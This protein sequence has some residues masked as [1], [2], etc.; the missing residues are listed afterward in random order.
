MYFT[1]SKSFLLAPAYRR[2]CSLMLQHPTE[3]KATP[4]RITRSG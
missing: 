4:K 3:Q 1:H 2:A